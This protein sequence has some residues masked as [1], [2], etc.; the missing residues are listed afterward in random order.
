MQE[1]VRSVGGD[2]QIV[3]QPGAGTLI[4]VHIPLRREGDRADL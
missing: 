1:R 4:E 2:L 3:S